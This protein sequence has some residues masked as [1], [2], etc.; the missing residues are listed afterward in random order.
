MLQHLKKLLS[1]PS[2]NKEAQPSLILACGALLLEL[3]QIDGEEAR[4]EQI[5]L[6]TALQE[7]YGLSV[8]EATVAI[9]QARKLLNKSVDSYIFTRILR[10]ECSVKE[11]QKI[12]QQ[13]WAVAY[14]DKLLDIQE[15]ARLRKCAD[16]LGLTHSEYLQAK[17]AAN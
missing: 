7:L 3:A 9:T 14:A 4:S 5:Q 1:P 12:M 6:I 11:R 2:D 8:E 10:D 17:H 16:L 15:E 13:L